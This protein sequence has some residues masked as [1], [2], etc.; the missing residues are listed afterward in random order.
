MKK[1]IL[2]LPFLVI[3]LI[4]TG[5]SDDDDTT[6]PDPVNE[7]E[8]IT[9][10]EVTLTATDGTDYVLSWEDICGVS[11]PLTC[12]Y[13]QLALPT[14]KLSAIPKA[15]KDQTLVPLGTVGSKP[16][17]HVWLQKEP[18]SLTYSR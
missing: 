5:C 10:V 16:N 7:Q 11:G 15:P 1:Q 12:C 6:T 13:R 18:L 2:L 17:P 14:D 9:T 3:A 4:F 8:V